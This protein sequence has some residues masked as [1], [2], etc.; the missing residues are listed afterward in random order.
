MVK[1]GR[2]RDGERETDI[3][4]VSL[5]YADIHHTVHSLMLYTNARRTPVA[6]AY[7]THLHLTQTMHTHAHTYTHTPTP[8]PSFHTHAHRPLLDSLSDNILVSS[9]FFHGF[10]FFICEL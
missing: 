6:Y 8:K 4:V 5:A 9:E 1:A 10:I 2:G 7:S 3:T